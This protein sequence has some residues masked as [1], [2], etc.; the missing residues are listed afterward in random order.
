[1]RGGFRRSSMHLMGLALLAM[2]LVPLSCSGDSDEEA[3]IVA[4][5]S[6]GC[7]INS[8]C[9]APLVCAFRRCHV[10]CTD[11]RD[12]PPDQRC[13]AAD[14]PLSVCQLPDERNCTYN[15]QCPPGQLCAI[16]AQ[17]RDQCKGDRDCVPMQMCVSGSCVE[18]SELQDGGLPPS[19]EIEAGS[20]TPCA[21]N[22][23]C[24]EPLACV[25]GQCRF[26]CLENRD[27][28]PTFTCQNA[29]CTP[30]DLD[31]GLGGAGN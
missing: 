15:S 23:N 6:E 27:C 14:R 17:C 30:P 13:V 11:S 25:D 16:D 20:G 18:P 3:V 10:Q 31:A 22:S 2:A 1:M 26:E 4:R 9:E 29:R 8:D 12:C 24:P 7:L 5:L 19:A 21:Y 28:F